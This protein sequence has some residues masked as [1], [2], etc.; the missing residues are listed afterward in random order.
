MSGAASR[1]GSAALHVEDGERIGS[2]PGGGRHGVG[3][4][5]KRSL[6][7]QLAVGDL[8]DGLAMVRHAEL[9]VAGDGADLHGF[10]APL[11][12]DLEDLFFAALG[13]H[14]QHALLAFG[15]H[16]LIRRHAG[17]ALGNAVELDFDAHAAAA[18]HL[19]GGAG[20]TRG[21]HVLN[22]HDGAGLH[23]F[24]AG[25]EQQLLHEGIAHLHVGAFLLGLFGK[26]RDW[27]WMRRGCH[28]ARCARRRRLRGCRRPRLWRRRCLP[29]G[30][31]RGRRRS[32]ADCRR[33]RARRGT[34]RR[35]WAR[36]SSCRNAR[37]RRP[38]RPKCGDSAPRSAE[39]SGRPKRSE[40]NTAMGRAPMVKMSRRMPPTPV[41][42][43]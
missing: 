33:S 25:F 22:A 29:C 2:L 27:P 28:R 4:V 12:E 6:V 39:S 18:A 36:R 17:F 23:G 26:F 9:A 42:A 37:C 41:A 43:P 10:Q 32:P 21:A 34:R 5:V 16:D 24:Q 3:A 8:G 1:T 14:Q 13:G 20:E 30:R 11:A 35:R 7:G 31:R 38:R 15:E 19:A 40:S